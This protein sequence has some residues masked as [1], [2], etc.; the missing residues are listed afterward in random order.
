MKR[1]LP[2]PKKPVKKPAKPAPAKQT[3]RAKHGKSAAG[4]AARAAK[5]IEAFIQNGGNATHAA[6]AAGYPARSAHV[7]GSR[8]LHHDKVK[9]QLA[10]RQGELQKASGLTTE[11]ILK[12]LAALCFSD[13]RKILDDSGRMR[14]PSTWPD[15]VAAAISSIEVFEE[16]EGRGDDRIKIGETKKIKLWEKNAALEKAMKHLGLFERDN[17][18]NRPQFI[19]LDDVDEAT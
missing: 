15:D 13:P 5:F 1:K 18:Q 14:D 19:Y 12:E 16:Y 11:R 9:A 3:E 8:L 4:F 6:I 7:Q 17:S 10:E 2:P